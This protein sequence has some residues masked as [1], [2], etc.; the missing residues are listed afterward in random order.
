MGAFYF[1]N[2]SNIGVDCRV[3]AKGAAMLRPYK[4]KIAGNGTA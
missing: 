4:G 2:R 3:G 1:V